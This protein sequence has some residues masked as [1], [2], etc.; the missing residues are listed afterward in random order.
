MKRISLLLLFA[1]ALA[2]LLPTAG[3]AV[4]LKEP[5]CTFNFPSIN[6]FNFCQYVPFQMR[7]GWEDGEL[8]WYI[9]TDASDQQI[10]C[11]EE[12][13]HIVQANQ[14]Q[15]AVS[16]CFNTINFAPRL[17][18]LAGQLAPVYIITGQPQPVFTAVPGDPSYSGLWQAVYVTFKPGAQRHCVNNAQPYDPI[19]NPTGL[20]T[21]A[22]ATFSV[23]NRAGNPII[24]KCPIMAVG[25]LAGPWHPE[26]G[27]TSIYRIPQGRVCADYTYTKVVWLPFWNIYC[28]DPIT[29]RVCVRQIVIPD[30]CDPPGLPFEDQLVPK[31]GA[32]DAPG[33]CLLT[34]MQK[35]YWQVGPQPVNQYPIVQACPSES[36]CPCLNFNYQYTPVQK[37]VVLQRNVPCCLP[38]SAVIT[39]EPALLRFLDSGCL[40]KIR[41]NQVIDGTILP[42]LQGL[43]INGVE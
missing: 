32:N 8:V 17:T 24:L 39:N 31:L 14:R 13:L 20:P 15:N 36:T 37:V 22:D 19:N 40:T 38:Q 35:F 30:A 43:P 16:L 5:C 4:L 27:N 26:P 21:M 2:M 12:F 7:Q 6:P 11:Q 9:C 18:A 3:S 29:K 28:Q 33:L 23:T 10:A 34:D 42:S 1:V 41:G 25:P